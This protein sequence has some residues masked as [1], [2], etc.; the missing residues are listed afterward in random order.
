MWNLPSSAKRV[1]LFLGRISGEKKPPFFVDTCKQLPDEW[2]CVMVGPLQTKLEDPVMG[3]KVLFVG[4]HPWPADA[5]QVADAVLLPSPSE[6]GPIVMLEA[7]GLKKPFFI[8]RTG[9]ADRFPDGV[10]LIDADETPGSVARRIVHTAANIDSPEVQRKVKY[11]S[12][13]LQGFILEDHFPVWDRIVPFVHHEFFSLR[14]QLP[15]RVDD[16]FGE[17]ARSEAQSPM[18]SLPVMHRGRVKTLTCRDWDTGTCKIGLQFGMPLDAPIPNDV[19]VHMGFAILEDQNVIISSSSGAI[20]CV[21]VLFS[22]SQPTRVA[23]HSF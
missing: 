10:F 1:L 2:V 23:V 18:R 5:L 7:W 17:V 16:A 21:R 14:N 20:L 15:I 9:L 3:S 19:Y 11:A 6:G 12:S 8:Y 13:V 22:T 4:T